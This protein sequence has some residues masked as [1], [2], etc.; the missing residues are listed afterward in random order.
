MKT[1]LEDASIDSGPERMRRDFDTLQKVHSS[2]FAYL[3]EKV[4]TIGAEH[5]ATIAGLNSRIDELE[6]NAEKLLSL[7]QVARVKNLPPAY[8]RELIAQKKV[9]ALPVGG[10][11]FKID[12]RMFN[13][14]LREVMMKSY[15]W[16]QA[17]ERKERRQ[18]DFAA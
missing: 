15:F 5:T 12:L 9:S 17:H 4:K 7:S 6:G 18:V 16:R 1:F 10:N 3:T 8:I 14:E 11:R 2:Q 13:R